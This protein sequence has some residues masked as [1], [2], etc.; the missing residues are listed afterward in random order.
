[1][2]EAASSPVATA[3]PRTDRPRSRRARLG[4]SGFLFVFITV[5]LAIGAV[6]SQNN[7]LFWIFGLAVAAVIVSG[8]VSGNSLM[9][10]RL[11]AGEILDTPV[12]EP[13]AVPYR[14]ISRNRLL[15]A[16]AMVVR[17]EPSQ[18]CEPTCVLHVEPRGQCRVSS[19]WTPTRRGPH[20]FDRVLV[21]SRFPFGFIIKTLEFSAPRT[22]LALPPIVELSQSVLSAV[23]AGH[24]EHRIKR[25]RRGVVGSYF[26]LRS[27]TPGDPRRAIAWRPSARRSELLVVEHAEPQGRSLWIHI[28][29]PLGAGPGAAMTER[30]IALASA[31]YRAGS[32]GGRTVAIWA[33]WAGVRLSPARGPGAE[34]RAARAL[35]V[36]DL[37]KISETDAP[38]PLR[39][40][41][42]VITIPCRACGGST[43]DRLDP[44]QP[45]DW[46]AP[47]AGLHPSLGPLGGDA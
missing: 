35:A 31:V 21:D 43:P 10:I 23:G 16:F 2:S 30:A 20:A 11:E 39:P 41:D 46:L 9:G 26:G 42:A 14:V 4:W 19:V 25:A 18:S 5:F 44:A 22:A 15:P 36:I 45:G 32:R 27:Y 13:R 17:E 28:E 7:L 47:G 29:R 3:T 12:G 38:P 37:G 6:N 8:F 24:S 33:P 1:M 34:L 40:G